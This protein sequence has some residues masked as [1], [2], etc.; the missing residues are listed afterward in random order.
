MSPQQRDLLTYLQAQPRENFSVAGRIDARRYL[1]REFPA[2][3][4]LLV[5]LQS[6]PGYHR[7]VGE[8]WMH[9]HD[10]Y[11]LWVATA[12]G[13][14]Y[15]C[16]NHRF[17]FGPGDVVLVDPLKIHGVLRM[18]RG[19]APLV[20]FFRADT[21][22][23]SGAGVDLG[24]LSAWDQ[25][26]ER[27]A[28]RLPGDDA[29]AVPVHGALL[30][31]ARAWFEKTHAEER[32]L[33]LK[34][35]LLD[36]LLHLRRAFRAHGEMAPDTQTARAARE[37]RLARVL[38]HLAEQGLRGVSQPA[39]ARVAGMS[40][41]RFRLF[42]KE[43]TGWGFADYLRDLRLERAARLLRESGDS[44][45]D[46]AYQAGFA[47]Q[48]HLQRLFKAKYAVSPLAYRKQHQGV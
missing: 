13:G 23:P 25:R 38:E 36:L 41:S 14:E 43:T 6:Y 34:F 9:W 17:A 32:A 21:V 12:A 45:A 44:V 48:S 18:E 7:M 3:L 27:I 10:Y 37:A 20:L 15:R 24:F 28:P 22:A 42:F 47:D 11:E 31:L 35:H 4:P 30:R 16:G 1:G 40:T 46:V 39:V 26:P 33:A 5:T 19:H 2:D 29:A 8:N